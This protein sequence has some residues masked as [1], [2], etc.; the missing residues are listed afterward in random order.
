MK[1]DT[2]DRHS[3][4]LTSLCVTDDVDS[5]RNTIL[6]IHD[7]LLYPGKLAYYSPSGL[8]PIKCS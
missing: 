6:P 1:T 4:G 2:S 3:A 7:E 8:S 5:D